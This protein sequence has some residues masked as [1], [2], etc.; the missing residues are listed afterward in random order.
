MA[1]KTQSHGSPN[2]CPICCK[3]ILDATKTRE[4]QEALECEGTCQKRIHCWCAG[5]H[6]QDYPTLSDSSDSW[7]CPSCRLK[8]YGQLIKS[9]VNTVETLKAEVASRQILPT[10]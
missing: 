3:A 7:T 5:V 6:K 2:V 4:G 8:E 10:S 9:L 1:S